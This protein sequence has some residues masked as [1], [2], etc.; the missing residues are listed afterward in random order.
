MVPIFLGFFAP[1]TIVV[2]YLQLFMEKH[3]DKYFC[4]HV[5]VVLT[6]GVVRHVSYQH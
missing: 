5:H 2:V 6:L 3:G 1:R 4:P